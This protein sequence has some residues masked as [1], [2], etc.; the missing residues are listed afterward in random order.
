MKT[1]L[2]IT[3]AQRSFPRGK[4][5]VS[6]T[7][8]KGTITFVNDTFVE[9]SGFDRDE[10][11]GEN[12][13]IIRHPDM[14][15]AAFQNLWDTVKSGRPWRGLVKNRCK[16][17][18]HYWVEALVVPVRKDNLTI[19]YM[20]VRTE[21]TPQQIT[22]AEALYRAL[23]NKTA[24]L[25]VP[26]WWQRQS[27]RAKQSGMLLVILGAQVLAAVA[28]M[29]GSTLGLSDSAVDWI[30]NSLFALT[31][32]SV[33]GLMVIQGQIMT[34]VLRI[35]G[36]L[37]H[38]A[39]GD[40]TDA[41]PLHRVD[42]LGQLNDALVTMQ[43][44]LKVMMTEIAEA[45]DNVSNSAEDL[46]RGMSSAHSASQ[47]QSDATSQI[48]AAVEQ[49]VVSVQDVAAGAGQA[50]TEVE[51]SRTLIDSTSSRMA[52][53]RAASADVVKTV[54]S[55]GNTMAELFKSIF[56]IGQITL[57]IKEIADQTNL[58]ALN[59]AIE[60]ARAG[61]QG[62]GFA[63]VA[64]EVRK[65]AERAKN[66]TDE[67]TATVQEVQ[68]ATQ[69]AVTEME[70]AGVHV[71]TTST[72]MDKAQESLD[73]VAAHGQHIVERS[74]Q[75]ANNTQQQSSAGTLIAKQVEGIVS[76]IDQTT[77]AVADA[78]SKA[79]EMNATAEGLRQL[80]RYFRFTR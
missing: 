40:L 4:Y 16:N 67:I 51:A 35:V 2:P 42:E 30:V 58:L 9:I 25:P 37:D 12:H 49:L 6:R 74:I 55:A 5:I 28:H 62:R 69:M 46:E 17:G 38:I 61:E 56:A 76:G 41:I 8:L 24:S 44:H 77:A 65:L 29:F 66:Q 43:A 79:H 1:N 80:M 54:S 19:G 10:L 21:V 15:P 23:V 59:A 53:S 20:S 36:R 33:V 31:A 75:I 73:E 3:R 48:A 32:A 45:A 50:A 60:A 13:N 71:A 34:I 11:I 39:Q 14:P 22:E 57:T 64:D 47:R 68:R 52:D 27:V 26:T 70:S 7:D 63:V 78:N 18:D 72:A